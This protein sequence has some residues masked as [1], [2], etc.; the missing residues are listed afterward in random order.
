MQKKKKKKGG[1]GGAKK[2]GSNRST[3]TFVLWP[4]RTKWSLSDPKVP[5]FSFHRHFLTQ[6]TASSVAYGFHFHKLS[7][8]TLSVIPPGGNTS[9][10]DI[11]VHWHEKGRPNLSVLFLFPIP[12]HFS[13]YATS[14]S[15]VPALEFQVPFLDW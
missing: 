10:T 3:C 8:L 7:G 13:L 12:N 15:L 6:C 14:S 2:Q 11:T 1:G 9:S 4:V 5:F